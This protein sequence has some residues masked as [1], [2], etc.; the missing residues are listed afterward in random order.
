MVGAIRNPR[1]AIRL[2][3]LDRRQ[4]A[5]VDAECAE[6][7]APAGGERRVDFALRGLDAA[8]AARDRRVRN[9]TAALVEPVGVEIGLDQPEVV[10]VQVHAW[11]R[12][13]VDDR[14]DRLAHHRQH[15]VALDFDL[16]ADDLA[17]D[18]DRE[19]EHC[20]GRIR[21]ELGKTAAQFV[22]HA[23]ELARVLRLLP[24]RLLLALVETLLAAALE[25]A[26]D[27]IKARAQSTEDGPVLVVNDRGRVCLLYTS[28]SP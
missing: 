20:F 17:R 27:R 24:L 19:I 9:E 2:R 5:G 1:S 12:L 22:E 6:H 13:F 28:P 16:A 25:R 3:A 11:M 8:A 21:F 14:A 7:A 10:G 18:L 26:S 15:R 4:F 23:F